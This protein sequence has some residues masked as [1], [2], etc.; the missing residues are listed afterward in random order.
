MKIIIIFLLFFCFACISDN[1]N[2]SI[3]SPKPE[4]EMV[5][6]KEKW[7]N[8]EG[9]NYPYRDMMVNDVVYND[10]IRN[11]TKNEILDL[12]GE[13]S[14]YREDK[15]FLHYTITRTQLGFWTLHTKTMVIKF[16]DSNTIDWIKIHE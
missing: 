16:S 7:R 12:L 15:N 8:Q 1:K 3:D 6:N 5:F 11:L 13:A 14:Y 2:Y 10:T 9:E 4:S